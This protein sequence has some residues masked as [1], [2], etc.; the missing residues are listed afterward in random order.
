M[1]WVIVLAW[2]ALVAVLVVFVLLLAKGES[3]DRAFSQGLDRRARRRAGGQRSSETERH[4]KPLPRVAGAAPAFTPQT[5]RKPLKRAHPYVDDE[6][7]MEHPVYVNG[8]SV[9]PVRALLDSNE[10]ADGGS[11]GVGG[12]AGRGIPVTVA[13]TTA[14]AD[15]GT[16][17]GGGAKP[18]VQGQRGH[19]Q[20]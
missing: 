9:L 11:E 16:D 1:V 10:G 5:V 3:H 19:D 15:A 14:D 7:T 17:T 18:A 2:I 20:A 12:N 13:D 6:D 8:D 4:R